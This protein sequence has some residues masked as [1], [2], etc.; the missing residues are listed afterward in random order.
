M[1]VANLVRAR[2]Q[3]LGRISYIR[4]RRRSSLTAYARK[5]C[6]YNAQAHIRIYSGGERSAGSSSL[7][8]TP[9]FSE[10]Y[11]LLIPV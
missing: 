9:P 2:G 7:R 6:N 1:I 4:S 3:G 10:A 5:P 8:L 11:V